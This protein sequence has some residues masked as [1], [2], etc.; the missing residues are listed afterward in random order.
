M[1]QMTEKHN[2]DIVMKCIH[3]VGKINSYSITRENTEVHSTNWPNIP[4]HPNKVL[5]LGG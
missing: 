4:A 5:V 2:H 1:V 3:N